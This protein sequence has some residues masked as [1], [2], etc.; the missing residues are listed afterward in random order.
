MSHSLLYQCFGMQGY[1]HLRIWTYGGETF[2]S[3]VRNKKRCGVCGSWQVIQKGY[4][5]RK[6]RVLPVGRKPV[7]AVVKMRRFFCRSC[8]RTRY[9]N[10]MIAEKKKHYT[11]ALERYVM[12]LCARMTIRDVAEHLRLNWRT[13]KEI[14]RK[15][16]RRNLPRE[17][18]LRK[19]RFL[20]IDE[21]SVR[22][23]HRYLT[24][25]VDLETGRVVYVGEGRR[26]ESLAPFFRRLKRIGVR[27]KAI[28]LDMWKPY[29]KA[30]RRYYRRLP[31]V[32]DVFHI[33]ADYSRV[34]NEIRVDEAQKLEGNPAFT[35]IKGS[36]YLLLKGQEKL[37][38][39]AR[40]KLERLLEINRPLS[41][42]Y[43]LKEELRQPWKL[44]MRYQAA[45]FLQDWIQKALSSGVPPLARFARKLRRHADGILNYFTFRISTAMVEGINNKI[46]VIKRKVYGYRDLNYFKLKIYNIHTTRYSLV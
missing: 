9:E 24:T 12:E 2:L 43:V 32:Y 1:R 44:P 14:D 23:G 17:E 42:A 3:V 11:H 25:V 29:A 35:L 8:G 13:V 21:V 16:L 41:I 10:W 20:G 31:L 15:R 40:E 18:D 46:K 45:R 30:I 19:I 38:E 6:L 34:L 7:F 37:S 26:V 36:R 22:K 33:L 5:W 27:P 39:P 28:A 4:R